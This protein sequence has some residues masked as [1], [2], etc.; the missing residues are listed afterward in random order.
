LMD[1][2][3][4]GILVTEVKLQV[5]DPPEQVKDAFHEVVRAREDRERLTNQALG[6]KENLIPKARGE[7]QKIL[8]DAE[9]FKE[10]RI[11]KAKGDVARFL[12]LLEEYQKA[13]KVTR[14]RLYLET[15]SRV[16][17]QSEKLV[18]DSDV[19][20][21]VLPFM[22]LGV[23]PVLKTKSISNVESGAGDQSQSAQSTFRR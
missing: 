4:S 7:V 20:A 3:Q 18:V 12:A 6:Y 11:L 19:K 13:K 8:R 9:G 22:P 2:Y 15:V 1:D 21:T 14:D 23:N 16:L 17:P 5:V 10:E